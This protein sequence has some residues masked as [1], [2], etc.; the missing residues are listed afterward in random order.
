METDQMTYPKLYTRNSN[1]SINVWWAEVLEDGSYITNYGQFDGKIQTTQP[2][3]CQPKNTGKKN[4]TSAQ[5]QAQK[6]VN[7]LYKKQRK[8]NYF[9]D[10]TLIDNAWKEPMTCSKY[11]EQKDKI[12]WGNGQFVDHKLNGVRCVITAK[13][14]RTRTNEIFRSIPHILEDLKPCD[15]GWGIIQSP[16]QE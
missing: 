7:A 10:I 9:D 1:G 11:R 8:S 12:K 5:D 14:A 16:L 13:G 6:E 2:V 3:T 15:F 4:A